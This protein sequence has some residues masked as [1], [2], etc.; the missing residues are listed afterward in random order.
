MRGFGEISHLRSS[1]PNLGIPRGK[2]SGKRSDEIHQLIESENVYCPNQ[3][4]LALPRVGLGERPALGNDP[5]FT[6][7][8][9]H[10]AC[11]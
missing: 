6:A 11:T 4:T 1:A 10:V 8:R 7:T 9:A 5:S 2:G 3:R